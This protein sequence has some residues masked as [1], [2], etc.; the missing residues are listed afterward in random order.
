M[1]TDPLNR[2]TCHKVKLGLSRKFSRGAFIK[3]GYVK[4]HFNDF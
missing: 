4:A 2:R 3:N 1:M